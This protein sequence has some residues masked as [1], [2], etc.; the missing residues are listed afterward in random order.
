MRGRLVFVLI[1]ALCLAAAGSAFAVS[2]SN[3]YPGP[4]E[5][6]IAG[7]STVYEPVMAGSSTMHEPGHPG[8]CDAC[9]TLYQTYGPDFCAQCH[10]T[11]THS[12][13]FDVSAA[14][15]GFAPVDSTWSMALGDDSG[16]RLW[17]GQIKCMTCH[18]PHSAVLGSPYLTM[19]YN[20]PGTTDR[21]ICFNCHP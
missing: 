21:P 10:E 15:A 3:G 6:V 19:P 2:A 4:K 18:T 13:P 16:T 20:R 8:D 12:H 11:G 1:A 5:P 7:L 9:H 17:G 14:A